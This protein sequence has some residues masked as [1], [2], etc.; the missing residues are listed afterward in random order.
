MSSFYN[1]RATLRSGLPAAGLAPPDLLDNHPVATFAIG[2][3]HSVTHWNKACES[4]LGWTAEQMLGSTRQ[5]RAFYAQRRPLLADLIVSGTSAPCRSEEFF[6]HL[7]ANGRWLQC[8]AAPLHDADGELTGAIQSVQDVSER[9]A[10]Q[11][12]LEQTERMASIGQLAA[13]VA[14]EINNPIGYIFSNFGALQEYLD[15]LFASCLQC[16]PRPRC[17]KGCTPCASRS[18][19]TTCAKTSRP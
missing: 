12:Q 10:A 16:R 1:E 14:H 13:G 3:D 7:G 11:L 9:R 6:P 4:L 8:A 18:N 5:W 15:Q 19:W 2:M 17:G